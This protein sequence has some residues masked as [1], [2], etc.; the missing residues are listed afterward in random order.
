MHLDISGL[1]LNNEIK[2]II[3]A[4]KSNTILISIHLNDNCLETAVREFVLRTMGVETQDYH[5]LQDN[6]NLFDQ[7]PKEIAILQKGFSKLDKIKSSVHNFFKNH[8]DKGP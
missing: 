7:H 8:H 1:N 4:V 2:P 6:L 3:K 5:K